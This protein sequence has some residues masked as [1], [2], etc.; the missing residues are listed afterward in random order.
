MPV[1]LCPANPAR[2]IRLRLADRVLT[3]RLAERRLWPARDAMPAVISCI[4]IQT[5]SPHHSTPSPRRW[6]L[7]THSALLLA[8]LPY[9][10]PVL[11]A[12]DRRRANRQL[13]SPGTVVRL[14]QSPPH[15]EL[16]RQASRSRYGGTVLALLYIL[17]A[18]TV[19]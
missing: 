10:S 17:C 5:L 3:G 8:E 14:R 15:V 4:A 19:A 13:P 6:P 11:L 16:T 18:Y 2:P 9:L 12:H 7:S 1:R